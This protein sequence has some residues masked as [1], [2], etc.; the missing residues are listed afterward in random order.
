MAFQS[1]FRSPKGLA[2][3]GVVVAVVACAKTATVTTDTVGTPSASLGAEGVA[4]TVYVAPFATD[5]AQVQVDPGGP[6]ERLQNDQSLLP[7]GGPLGGFLNPHAQSSED[8]ASSPKV[9]AVERRSAQSLQSD[10][11]DALGLVGIRAS[12]AIQYDHGIPNSLLLSGQFIKID[13]GSQLKRI[14]IGLG[15]GASYLETQAQLRDLSQPQS[16]PILSF[17]TEGDS[18]IKP[19]VM[20]AGPAGAAMTGG[21]VAGAAVSG[22]RA[23]KTGTPE[24]IS[25]TATQIAA[26]VKSYYE[27]QGWVVV[28]K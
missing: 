23:M 17:A 22:A 2:S 12:R 8:D 1:I 14:A 27:K 21:G 10:L 18:G 11:L 7:S 15:A 4:P 16:A 20:V 26:Y 25:H 13:Q 28:Q 6:L 19:G 9:S 5:A 24:D 3:M